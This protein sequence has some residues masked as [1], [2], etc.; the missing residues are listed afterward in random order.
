MQDSVVQFYDDLADDYH[1]IFADWR[2]SIGWQGEVLE[3]LI[4]QQMGPGP[5]SVL[6][7][8]CGIGT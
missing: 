3:R 5:L 8:S 7:C 6:D 2:A 1:L 4:R